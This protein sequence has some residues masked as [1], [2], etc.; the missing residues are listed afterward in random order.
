MLTLTSSDLG[1]ITGSVR[2][3][4][5]GKRTKNIDKADRV[6]PMAA[7]VH[8][9]VDDAVRDSVILGLDKVDDAGM[10]PAT[11]TRPAIPFEAFVIGCAR[12]LC[13]RWEIQGGQRDQRSRQQ[14]DHG[15]RVDADGF[16][17]R[18][19]PRAGTVQR[20]H[21]DWDG[22]SRME[23]PLE[24]LG[25]DEAL[26]FILETLTVDQRED[27]ERVN[28]ERPWPADVARTQRFERAARVRSIVTGLAEALASVE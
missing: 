16:L 25:H 6:Q 3:F 13:A 2:S 21:E 5:L 19:K 9:L 14:L 26:A 11:D 23:S 8:N 7:V 18:G 27:L 24:T 12:T 22:V 1:K 4:V 20:L 10:I 28:G 17:H 15:F